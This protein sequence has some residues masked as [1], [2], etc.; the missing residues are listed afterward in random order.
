MEISY[1][2]FPLANPLAKF[3]F[4]EPLLPNPDLLGSLPKMVNLLEFLF[5]LNAYVARR[6][7]L[8]KSK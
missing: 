8:A 2:P 4:A 1:P 7:A 3:E 6:Y 5:H